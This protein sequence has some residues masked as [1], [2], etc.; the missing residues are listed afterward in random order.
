MLLFVVSS[1]R[2]ITSAVQ[3]TEP[4]LNSNLTIG[5]EYRLLNNPTAKFAMREDVIAQR[6][7]PATDPP[8]PRQIRATAPFLGS[9]SGIMAP[10]AD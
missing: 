9:W 1:A 3:A 7:S 8:I 6:P 4:W 10:Q 5:H 2:R